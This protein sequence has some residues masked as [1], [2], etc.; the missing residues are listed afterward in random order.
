MLKKI[1]NLDTFHLTDTP[2]LPLAPRQ[3]YS[4]VPLGTNPLELHR[5]PNIPGAV[6]GAAW[7]MSLLTLGL[8]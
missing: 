3:A 8:W 2:T 6:A 1:G 4:S 5:D 7:D